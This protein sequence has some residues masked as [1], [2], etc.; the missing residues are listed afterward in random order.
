M[1]DIIGNSFLK[2]KSKT[3]EKINFFLDRVISGW[4]THHLTATVDR[5]LRAHEFRMPLA[6]EFL[7]AEWLRLKKPWRRSFE[8]PSHPYVRGSEKQITKA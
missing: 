6:A 4:Y 1:L 8:D 5:L 3:G 7:N 2:N